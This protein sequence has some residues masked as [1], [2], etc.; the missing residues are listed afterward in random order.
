MK[1]FTRR[2]FIKTS[3]AGTIAA[4]SGFIDNPHEVYADEKKLGLIPLGKSGLTVSRIAFG[5]GTLGWEKE[6]DQSN[7]DGAIHES[8]THGFHP[9]RWP[10]PHR[11]LS[12]PAQLRAYDRCNLQCPICFANANVKG[13]VYEPS[14]DQILKMMEFCGSLN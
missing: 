1:K 4:G 2:E 10:Y 8:I 14:M 7:D 11:V 6:S 9:A 12:T 13:W 5:T 3:I